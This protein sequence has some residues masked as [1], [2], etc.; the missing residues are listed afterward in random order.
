MERI[1]CSNRSLLLWWLLLF[2]SF[3]HLSE[4]HRIAVCISGQISRWIP[5]FFYSGMIQANPEH[6]FSLFINLQF[7]TST[8]ITS[9]FTTKSQINFQPTPVSELP[10]S[11]MLQFVHDLYTTNHSQIVVLDIIPPKTL[12][13]WKKSMKLSLDRIFLYSKKQHAILNLYFHQ[14][15]CFDQIKLHEEIQQQAF[16]YVI[17]TRED[18]YF[19]RPIKLDPLFPSHHFSV[20]DL[21]SIRRQRDI[22]LPTNFT[23]H[24]PHHR[25]CDIVVKDCLSWNGTNMRWQLFSAQQSAMILQKRMNY[26]RSLYKTKTTFRNPEIFEL[27]QFRHF[28]LNV[29]EY[30]IETI[31]VA[32]IR[33][34]GRNKTLP[35]TVP[36]IEEDES[37]TCFIPQEIGMN[38]I[39][40]ALSNLVKKRNCN[41]L[42]RNTALS[43]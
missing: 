36:S 22:A 16:D 8:N 27:N 20:D 11:D 28:G 41:N 5:D 9:V 10:F 34:L 42:L 21:T 38:C 30:S 40:V 37:Q 33:F 14:R 32:A 2:A 15:R 29:C 26:Y 25:Y 1:D 35:V 24:S 19:F 31:P 17:N 7:H 3:F 12:I 39:P 43:P 13:E 6:L 18:I 4:T 23:Q